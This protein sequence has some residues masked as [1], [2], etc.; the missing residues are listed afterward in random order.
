[1]FIAGLTFGPLMSMRNGTKSPQHVV[2]RAAGRRKGTTALIGWEEPQGRNKASDPGHGIGDD[3][4]S[5][6]GAVFRRPP[7]RV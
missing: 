5:G 3:S 6:V 7:P 4:V 1:M 2:G